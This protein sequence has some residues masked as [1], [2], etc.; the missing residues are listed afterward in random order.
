MTSIPFLLCSA[1]RL[2]GQHFNKLLLLSKKKKKITECHDK[3]SDCSK[4]VLF[5]RIL[6]KNT[7]FSFFFSVKGEFLILPWALEQCTVYL[8]GHLQN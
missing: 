5:E 6:F 2:A 3:G 7:S 4:N 1:F 8:Y